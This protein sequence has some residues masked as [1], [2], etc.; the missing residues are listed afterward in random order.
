MANREGEPPTNSKDSDIRSQQEQVPCGG[1][2]NQPAEPVPR[3]DEVEEDE[4][5][6][7]QQMERW[8]RLGEHQPIDDLNLPPRARNALIRSQILTIYDAERW[9]KAAQPG[10]PLPRVGLKT[11]QQ[12]REAIDRWRSAQSTA[13][14][15][16][17]EEFKPIP[18]TP[19]EDNHPTTPERHIPDLLEDF[20]PSFMPWLFDRASDLD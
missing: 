1:G 12:L 5:Q 8:Y 4:E 3:T 7:R 10:W 11:E 19:Q 14:F 13:G 15:W 2:Q 17:D 9:F 6:V 16:H 18:L 20:N